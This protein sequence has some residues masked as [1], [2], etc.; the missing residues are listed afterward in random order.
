[1]CKKFTKVFIV[2]VTCSLFTPNNSF[3]Q[4]QNDLERGIEKLN[5]ELAFAKELVGSF[6]N[7]QAQQLVNRAEQL[8][9]EAVRAFKNHNFV[10]SGNKV[11]IAFSLLEQ[12]VTITL[13]GPVRRWRSRLEELLRRADYE[14]LGSQHKE[15]ERILRNAKLNQEAA[16]K[17]LR[18]KNVSK[19][20]EHYRVAVTLAERALDLVKNSNLSTRDKILEAQ[21]K[22]EILRGRAQD[23]VEK[24]S[25]VRAKQIF[26]Q[27][28][29]LSI[30]AQEAIQNRNYQLANK[31]Y[32]QGVLLLL[33]AMDLTKGQSLAAVNQVDRAL[34]RLRELIDNSR[35]IIQRTKRPRAKLLFERAR[36]FAN[37]AELAVNNGHSYKALWK[38]EL[39]EN[40]LKRARRIA[41]N[42]SGPN[43]S[44]KISQEITNTKLDIS[45]VRRRVSV[46]SPKDAEVLISMSQFAINKAEQAVTAGFERFALEAVLAAQRFLTKAER[47]LQ[48][49]ESSVIS[50]DRIQIRLNQL[51]AAI[52]E[53]ESRIDRSKQDWNRRLLQGAKDIRQIAV[54]SLQKGN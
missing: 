39:A 51:D 31:L 45:D 3:S 11:K 14:I 37:E 5:V 25:N 15:A 46:N 36:K 12:A 24:S 21:R 19:A 2:L 41:E 35:E 13:D 4:T 6:N 44:L 23:L 50:K 40:M 20:L 54:A 52:A 49:Q 18:N 33:R 16:E 32:N 29:K 8:R 34:I 10:V 26:A 47:L 48:A 42:R 28:I 7:K 38:I 27:A 22:F 9:N 17:A 1:M 30:S 53:S 43:I